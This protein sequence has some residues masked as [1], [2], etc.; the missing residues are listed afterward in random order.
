MTMMGFA[1]LGAGHGAAVYLPA[2]ESLGHSCV[3]LAA[4]TPRQGLSVAQ[5]TDWRAAIKRAD[6]DAVVIALPPL[7][8]REAV[9]AAAEAGKPFLCEKPAGMTVED[10]SEMLA[11]AEKFG[12]AHAV[13][14]QFRYEP[15]FIALKQTI[16]SGAI[17]AI[18][19]IDVDWCI[20][21]PQSRARPWSWRNDVAQGGGVMLNFCTHTLDYLRWCCGDITLKGRVQSVLV[22][23]RKDSEG[24]ERETTAPDACDLLLGF[25]L[26]GIASVRVTNVALQP[27]GHRVIVRGARG[28][29]EVWHRPPFRAV[30]LTFSF[31]GEDG[32]LNKCFGPDIGMAATGADSRIAPTISLV[33]DFVRAIEG[34]HVSGLPTLSDALAVHR[35][36]A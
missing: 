27:I 2:L 20:G 24:I 17:G 25:G 32:Q 36:L 30:D 3:I 1:I 15:A 33:A 6:V 7:L 35:L 18:E 19:L 14:F 4:R 13:G 23:Q 12:Q 28:T 11:T 21:G 10:V 16:D 22:P 26:N 5:G 29:I 34:I 9:L 8:Q 31:C